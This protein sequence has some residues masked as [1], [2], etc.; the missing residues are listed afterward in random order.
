MAAA[1]IDARAVR[2]FISIIHTHAAGAL[3]G[4]HRPGLLQLVRIHPE[5]ETAVTS[6]FRIGDID[7]M[8]EAALA[9][10]AAGHNVYVE[11]R[12]VAE[13]TR[14]RGGKGDTRGVFA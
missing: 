13:T 14:G 4:A 9:D 11:G 6:R 12:T 10:A 7:G 5:S 8:A 1:L 3:A 2:S